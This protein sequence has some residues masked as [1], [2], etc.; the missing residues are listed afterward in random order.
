MYHLKMKLDTYTEKQGVSL[1]IIYLC[2]ALCECL[3]HTNHSRS[4]YS[5]KLCNFKAEIKPINY[6]EKYCQRHQKYHYEYYCKVA[7]S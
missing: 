7:Q 1:P 4:Q 2:G 6:E 3:H 5:D